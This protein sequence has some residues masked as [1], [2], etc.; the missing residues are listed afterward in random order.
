MEDETP[1]MSNPMR[2]ASE[3]PLDTVNRMSQL[4]EPEYPI[5]GMGVEAL[6]PTAP[7]EEY[8]PPPK[9]RSLTNVSSMSRRSG[10]LRKRSSQANVA[11]PSISRSQSKDALSSAHS[12]TTSLAQMKNQSQAS[13]NRPGPADYGPVWQCSQ[14]LS[15]PAWSA[16]QEL[17][18]ALERRS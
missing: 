10:I 7:P 2:P 16:R 1:D 6:W 15:R 11:D 9:T 8:T 18:H 5:G 3:R 4:V 17:R 13:L 12:S 14:Q